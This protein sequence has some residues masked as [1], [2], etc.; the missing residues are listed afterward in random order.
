MQPRAIGTRAIASCPASLKHHTDS[1]CDDLAFKKCHLVYAGH[2]FLGAEMHWL[3][4]KYLET[5]W[6]K[7]LAWF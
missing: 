2:N 4:A 3:P 1:G 6:K 7:Y 5:W